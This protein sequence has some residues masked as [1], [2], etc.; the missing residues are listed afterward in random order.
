M[1][2]VR[3]DVTRS[4]LLSGTHR[5][6]ALWRRSPLRYA[7]VALLFLGAAIYLTPLLWMISSSLKPE[8]QILA[9]PLTLLPLPPRWSNYAEALS[10]V[11]FGRYTLN[12][13]FLSV[14]NIVG[15]LLSCTLV[16]Y[17][18]ARL[19][20]PGRQPLFLVLLATMMLPYPV[21]MVPL[22]MLYR[23]LGWVNTF[24]PLTVPSFLGHPFYIFLLRQFMLTIPKDFEEAARVDGANIVQII[25]Y[26]LLP[27]IKPALATAAIFT[28]Q[29]TWNDFIGP[30]IYLHNQA[31]YTVT[32][33][34]NFFR[35]TYTVRWAYLM[36]ASLVTVLPVVFVF[37][38]AQRAF[39]EGI[40][41]S[42]VRG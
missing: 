40:T 1:K 20:A 39:V 7:A 27:L 28:F 16:A 14:V 25:G 13:L 5:S 6:S 22:Y 12:T 8:R 9:V 24:L 42:G 17:G 31:L 23:S 35:A 10:Y 37:L 41:L 29:S 3:A 11:P 21:T 2:A 26:V 36:A 15:H 18:F 33:G 19:D 30:L 38:V 4:E 34:L 32:L